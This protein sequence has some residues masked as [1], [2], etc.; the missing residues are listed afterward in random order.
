M[1]GATMRRTRLCLALCA[2]TASAMAHAYSQDT[3]FSMT[4]KRQEHVTGGKDEAVSAI[5]NMGKS[6]ID[7][8]LA[9]WLSRTDITYDITESN[10]PVGGIETIQPL[11]MDATNTIFWQGR[12]S[13]QDTSTTLNFGLGYRYLTPSKHWMYGANVFYD[14]N[15]RFHHSRVGLGAELFSPYV[16]FRANYYN[17]LS[18]LKK[19]SSNTYEQALDGVDLSAETPM[20]YI[21]WMR[22]TAQGYHWRG[23]QTS[24]I[25]GGLINARIF[26]LSHVEID[27]GIAYDNDKHRQLFVAANIYLDKPVFIEYNLNADGTISNKAWTPQNLEA[28]RLQKVIRQND[29]VVE[30]R[31][32]V[33][34]IGI[35]RGT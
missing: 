33:V 24:D 7:N 25:N 22:F 18:G 14:N 20:P 28:M 8:K 19:V 15:I 35:G 27:A 17:V 23:D 31:R 6:Y 3:D 12:A 16:T 13:Y 30:N 34:G 11:F 9:G 5:K 1:Q 21:P 32:G 4:K 26:P 29:I 2:I 10:K